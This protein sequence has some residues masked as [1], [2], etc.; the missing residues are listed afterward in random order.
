[1]M[2]WP[3]PL[4]R[5]LLPIAPL[6]MLG[7][8][9]ALQRIRLLARGWTQRLITFAQIAFVI[10]ILVMNLPLYAINVWVAG[11]GDFYGTYHAGIHRELQAAAKWLLEKPPEPGEIAISQR[12]INNRR[13]YQSDGSMRALYFLIDRPVMK[14]PVELCH[15]PDAQLIEWAKRHNVRYYLYQPP[16]S[17]TLHFRGVPWPLRGHDAPPP[18]DTSW[19]LYEISGDE[20]RRIELPADVNWPTH[21]P[22]LKVDE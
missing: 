1:V 20:A 5:Y 16:F 12:V 6:L 3:H 18:T 8:M 13:I 9:L 14:V 22:G 10:S 7:A 2:N 19:R 21:V 15:E 17:M 4:P 11:A